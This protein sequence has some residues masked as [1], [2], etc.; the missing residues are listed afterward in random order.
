MNSAEQSH[1]WR[2]LFG[3]LI[4]ALL[5]ATT[6]FVVMLWN[7]YDSRDEWRERYFEAFY[8]LEN[9]TAERDALLPWTMHGL[10]PTYVIDIRDG[11]CR[12]EKVA[13]GE[14]FQGGDAAEVIQGAINALPT[15]GG[16]VLLRSGTYVLSRGITDGNKD[17][18][19]L[20]GEGWNTTLKIADGTQEIVVSITDQ[21]GWIISDIAIDGNKAN[22][23]QVPGGVPH[24]MNQNGIQLF[25]TTHSKIVRC[26]VHDTIFH[27]INLHYQSTDNVVEDCLVERCGSEG[28]YGASSGILVFSGSPRNV[29]R[30]N[31][32]IDNHARGIYISAYSSDCLVSDNIIVGGSSEAA[33]GIIVMDN[34]DRVELRNNT[35]MNPPGNGVDVGNRYG[36]GYDGVRILG[37]TIID[38]GASGIWCGPGGTNATISGNYIKGAGIHGI[39]TEG[40][41]GAIT[42]NRIIKP[43]GEAVYCEGQGTVVSG[44]VVE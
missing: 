30:R 19:I 29:V 22:N 6:V 31:R 11:L 5:I 3:A 18:V 7:A 40:S 34:S 37:N 2:L 23:E 10:T 26:Y 41:G 21:T 28:D 35:I 13:D 38:P 36:P 27:G 1:R 32:C 8:Q 4:A 33:Q 44:N 20:Q 17:F 14:T 42:D 16:K 12:A 15:S 43:S 39:W 9:V 25:R 24:D